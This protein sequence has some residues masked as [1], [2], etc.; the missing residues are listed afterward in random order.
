METIDDLEIAI[1]PKD[2]GMLSSIGMLIA[3]L[4][5]FIP[6]LSVL[7]LHPKVILTKQD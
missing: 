1:T 2:L 7:R 3:I 6:S 5:S 4:S